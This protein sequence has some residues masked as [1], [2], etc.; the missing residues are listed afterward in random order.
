MSKLM[1]YLGLIQ[2]CGTELHVVEET[3]W[4]ASVDSDLDGFYDNNLNCSW[5]IIADNHPTLRLE[6]LYMDIECG[7]DYLR[8]SNQIM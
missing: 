1:L 2:Q 7:F 5:L 3:G 4:L 6:V 8:V